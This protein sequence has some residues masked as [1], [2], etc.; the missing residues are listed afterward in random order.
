MDPI[1][2]GFESFDAIGHFRTADNGKPVDASGNLTDTDVDG[3]F[4]GVVELGQ[5]LAKSEASRACFAGN[6]LEYAMGRAVD[7]AAACA[8]RA[9][10]PDFIAGKSSVRDLIIALVS[11]D[12]FVK[13]AQFAP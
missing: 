13:R 4:N 10:A 9:L 8:L 2:F 11:S 12:V 3:D 1:G 5:K 7:D 6:W